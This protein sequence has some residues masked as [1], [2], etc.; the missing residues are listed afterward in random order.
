LAHVHPTDRRS[1]PNLPRGTALIAG[2]VL[3]TFIVTGGRHLW[4]EWS[5]LNIEQARARGNT[6]IGYPGISPRVSFAAKPTAWIHDEGES[7]LI[8]GGWKEGSGHQ[9]FRVGL[10]D[11]HR[12][13][14]SD[15][16]GRDVIQAIDDPVVEQGGGTRWGRIPDD[17]VVAGQRL[18]GVETAYPLVVLDKVFVVND[19]IGE[20]PYLVALDPF[21]AAEERVGVYETVLDGRRVTMG[22]TGYLYGGRPLL[23]DRGTESL[24]VV[25]SGAM[26]A[27]AGAHKGRA[28]RRLA[29]PVTVAWGRWRSD[30][31]GSRLVVG[32]DRSRPLPEL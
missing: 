28:L 3:M 23:Y 25:R 32:A 15:P 16:I 20:H 19:T 6:V 27:I 10:G 29:R 11:V 5:V 24:W 13:L 7:T 9:W 17:A 12:S 30:H 31:P 8:W 1:R 4:G 14:M 21:V 26:R 2:A 22:M 18:G